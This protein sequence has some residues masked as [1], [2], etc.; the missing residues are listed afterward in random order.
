MSVDLGVIVLAAGAA[1][2]YGAPKLALPINGVSLVRRAALASLAVSRHVVVVVG[3]HRQIIEPLLADLDVTVVFNETWSSGMGNSLS[4]GVTRLRE[5]APQCHRVL[6]VLA[7][8]VLIDEGDLK[9]LV[10]THR[11]A[12]NR[13]V[14][15]SYDGVLGVPCVFPN[16]YFDEI[17][18]LQGDVGARE[19]LNRHTDEVVAVPMSR[20]RIDIDTPEDY[21][22]I[23]QK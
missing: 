12:P 11:A 13:I 23:L 14:A 20:A 17:E 22:R 21:A 10:S 5:V 16:E 3:A 8:Q 6:I 18:R 2:R 4:F 19:L 1:K 9:E 7:D 15:A